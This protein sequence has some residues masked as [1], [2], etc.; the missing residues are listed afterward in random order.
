[1]I[2]CFERPGGRGNA[3]STNGQRRIRLLCFAKLPLN[4]G[5]SRRKAESCFFSIAYCQK[6]SKFV[7]GQKVY[8]YVFFFFFFY[9]GFKKVFF[10]PYMK[11]IIAS[12]CQDLGHPLQS[13][14]QRC[15]PGRGDVPLKKKVTVFCFLVF[16]F[17]CVFLCCF[18][19]LF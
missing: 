16:L 14:F 5:F 7:G 1:M 3:L 15:G 9:Q 10:D 18:F 11:T 13:H 17:V 4:H 19:I 12:L 6:P 2:G 8:G